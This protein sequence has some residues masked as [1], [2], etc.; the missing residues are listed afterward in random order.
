MAENKGM[1]GVIP[2][3]ETH[4]LDQA[5]TRNRSSHR[6]PYRSDQGE[7]LEVHES[8]GDATYL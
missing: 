1:Y 6:T 2:A 3:L 4:H 5:S 7:L 8:G